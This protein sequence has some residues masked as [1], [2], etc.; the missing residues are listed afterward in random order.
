M[1]FIYLDC[2]SGVSGDMLVGSLLDGGA[3]FEFLQD[4]ISEMNFDAKLS[5]SKTVIKGISCSAFKVE[6]PGSPPLRHL[7][8]I[9]EIISV[10]T[11]PEQVKADSV[12]VF[13]RLAEAEANVHGVNK[14]AIHFHEIGAVDTLVDIVGT[15]LCLQDMGIKKVYS[16]PLPWSQ[17]FIDISHGRYPLPA[18]ATARLLLGFPCV[19]NSAGMELVTPTGAALLTHI[20][21][22]SNDITSFTP[23]SIG[24]GAGTM[25]R[26]D[27]VPNLL[28]MV[29][30]QAQDKANS[31]Q[32]I[33]IL[34][35]ELDDLN[36]ELFSHLY[37]LFLN[38][39]GVLDFFTT[40][41]FMKKNRPGTL[42]TIL[43]APESTN[44]LS[45]L[46]MR[47]SGSLGVRYRL[48]ERLVLPRS[49]DVLETPWG[50]VRIKLA[51]LSEGETHIKPEYE[52]CH[53]I[54][55]K[56]GLP[57]LEVYSVIQGLL[58]KVDSRITPTTD[59]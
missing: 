7:S 41:V 49:S 50:P 3:S 45:H 40:P 27:G 8:Q 31:K 35:A 6:S 25:V 13:N 30:A 36:P 34:E 56:H 54:A 46:L 53:A 33:A 10:S 32:T 58:R 9:E 55:V 59:L 29:H 5:C 23:L 28:R 14:S 15:F 4:C 44:E 21:S 16:S 52:D 24:Y 51:Q 42:I 2:F 11:L 39:A 12:A 22:C 26:A 17:G 18:P 47:E 37:D 43:A 19:F 57:L 48:Q 1:E 38:H 20:A